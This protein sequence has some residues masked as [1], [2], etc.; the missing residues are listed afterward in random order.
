[1]GDPWPPH[2]ASHS[3][4]V[5][6]LIAWLLSSQLESAAAC[7]QPSGRNVG[8]SMTRR[9]AKITMVLALAAF[10]FLVTFNNVT[11]YEANFAFVQHVLSMDTT[12]PSSPA[13]Y[14]A[15][16]APEL[17]HAAYWLI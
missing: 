17:W 14:R 8:C 2:G 12:F 16:T 1:S 5:P 6:Q 11:D 9:Y 3:P 7:P 4:S 10:A 15:I 13:K